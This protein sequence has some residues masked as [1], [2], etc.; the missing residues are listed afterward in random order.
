MQIESISNQKFNQTN[1]N[2]T[3][4]RVNLALMDEFIAPG[5]NY[6][7]ASLRETVKKIVEHGF[8]PSENA[9]DVQR[10]TELLA[11]DEDLLLSN[12]D[13]AKILSK[14]ARRDFKGFMTSVHRMLI[15]TP[16]ATDEST[17]QTI[18]KINDIKSAF[19]S[20][21]KDYRS[22]GDSDLLLHELIYT[23]KSKN[24]IINTRNKFADA[25]E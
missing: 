10:T 13:R 12:K 4:K 5:E 11:K 19:A 17:I 7:K 16:R 8:F 2:F 9:V 21:L 3:A 22:G 18:E 1:Q 15:K 23:G 14:V 24:E 6:N 25:K 20:Q